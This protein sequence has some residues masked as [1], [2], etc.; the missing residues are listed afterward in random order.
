LAIGG[1]V[2]QEDSKPVDKPK[3]KSG[4]RRPKE[5]LSPEGNPKAEI[6]R[7]PEIRNPKAEIAEL[8]GIGSG[9]NA[10]AT[11]PSVSCS[12]RTE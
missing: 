12:D 5:V 2:R 11:G 3:K 10:E 1:T 4:G 6:R 9:L 7:K 8:P